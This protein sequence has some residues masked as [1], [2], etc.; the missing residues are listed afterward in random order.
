M[1][2][3]CNSSVIQKDG[4]SLDII[5]MVEQSYRAEYVPNPQQVKRLF[6]YSLEQAKIAHDEKEWYAKVK[7][8]ALNWL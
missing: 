7:D 6:E 2:K 4:F 8:K 5:N 1:S 3:Q